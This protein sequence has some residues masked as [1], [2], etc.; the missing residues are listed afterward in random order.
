MKVWRRPGLALEA[1]GNLE[2]RPEVADEPAQRGGLL[3]REECPALRDGG[4]AGERGE[5]GRTLG[6]LGCPVA[7]V[8]AR[9]EEGRRL[10]VGE[11]AGDVD[12]VQDEGVH[13]SCDA[14]A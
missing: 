9:D 8:V 14:S 11:Q 10:D 6:F 7:A 13:A 4:G 1:R 12:P 3:E 2:R 5:S